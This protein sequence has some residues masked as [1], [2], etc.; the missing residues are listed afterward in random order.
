MA[1]VKALL[2]GYRRFYHKHFRGAD[3]TLPALAAK[4]QTPK[5]LIIACS[6]SRV[7]PAIITD[8]E[9]GEIF[10]IRNVA[11]LVPPFQPEA[12][13]YHGTSAAL[14][15]GVQHLQVKH[16]VVLGHSGCAGIDALLHCTPEQADFS[17]IRPWVNI[18]SKA[19]DYTENVLGSVDHKDACPTCEQQAVLVSLQN[20]QT[21]PWVQE[22]LDAGTLKLHGWYFHLA[23]G[24]LKTW[25]HQENRFCAVDVTSEE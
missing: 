20:L 13:S 23:S 1:E 16:I 24:Q 14:E 12:T 15:F 9:P 17:F 4:G 11:N 25:H 21:F 3:A 22:K 8:A 18:A 7:D 5:T 10:V 19:R 2:D 6:D